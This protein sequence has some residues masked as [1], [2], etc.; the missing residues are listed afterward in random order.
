MPIVKDYQFEKCHGGAQQASCGNQ[1]LIAHFDV[2]RRSPAILTMSERVLL[3]SLVVGLR[4]QKCIEIGTCRGGSALIIGAALDDVGGGRLWC[5]DQQPVID[6][7]H[8][9]QIAHR[10]TLIDKPSPD[11]LGLAAA[12][13][14]GKFNFA[15]IDGDHTT[16]GVIRDVKGLLRHLTDGAHLL[17]HDAHNREVEAGIDTILSDPQKRFVDC[18]LIS[19]ERTADLE[20]AHVFWGGLRLLRFAGTRP[21]MRQQ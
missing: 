18:G 20:R 6:A 8:W 9:Q 21:G 15:F 19:T 11:A 14:G 10:A 1:P 3:Y 7:G 4:P 12:A 5:V 16:E 17:F 13:A 2:V